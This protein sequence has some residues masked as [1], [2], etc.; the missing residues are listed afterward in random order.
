LVFEGKAGENDVF[1]EINIEKEQIAGAG[2]LLDMFHVL[3]LLVFI[4][5]KKTLSSCTKSNLQR[6]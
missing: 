3:G 2:N 4:C 5:A 1:P 6:N